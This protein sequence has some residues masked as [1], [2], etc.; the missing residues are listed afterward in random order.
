[1]CCSV[2][3]CVAVCCRAL[4]SA[5]CTCDSNTCV[6]VCCSVLQCVTVCCSALQS[7]RC[8][9]DSKKCLNHISI[10]QDTSRHYVV[11]PL[12]FYTTLSR[13]LYDTL[14]NSLRHCVEFYTTLIQVLVTLC[15]ILYDALSN[16]TGLCRTCISVAY[17][18]SVLYMYKC[19]VCRV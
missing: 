6:A 13:I 3:Q 19:C 1:M 15:R 10:L 4:Q 9:C 2:L 12:E 7:A 14:W 5:R 17:V 16:C 18:V 11:T 8:T